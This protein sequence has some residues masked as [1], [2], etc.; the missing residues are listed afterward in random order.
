[1]EE[2]QKA[3]S[4][5]EVVETI[6]SWVVNKLESSIQSVEELINK[7][8]WDLHDCA[9]EVDRLEDVV[10]RAVRLQNDSGSSPSSP[11]PEVQLFKDDLRFFSSMVKSRIDYNKVYQDRDYSQ[12]EKRKQ[13]HLGYS[14]IRH[15]PTSGSKRD[16]LDQLTE[17]ISSK[18]SSQKKIEEAD[19][20]EI[21]IVQHNHQGSNKKRPGPNPYNFIEDKSA[22]G[23]QL[24]SSKSKSSTAHSKV[25]SMI[26]NLYIQDSFKV[27]PTDSFDLKFPRPQISRRPDH[28]LEHWHEHVDPHDQYI[29][30]NSS[31]VDPSPYKQNIE[32][33]INILDAERRQTHY[34]QRPR[35]IH[36]RDGYYSGIRR[37]QPESTDRSGETTMRE[38]RRETGG[39]NTERSY[40]RVQKSSYSP[41]Q[42]RR[43][44]AITDR[45][46]YQPLTINTQTYDDLVNQGV[47]ARNPNPGAAIPS[48]GTGSMENSL[49]VTERTE[50][51][52]I[53]NSTPKKKVKL[54]PGMSD[55]KP[56]EDLH[57]ISTKPINDGSKDQPTRPKS[58]L[59][60]K[61]DKSKSSS[62]QNIK[63]IIKYPTVIPS[64]AKML[65][66]LDVNNASHIPTM[67]KIEPS[68]QFT[69]RSSSKH[70]IGS[71]HLQLSPKSA[72]QKLDE[73]L[74][75]RTPSSSN[76]KKPSNISMKHDPLPEK[77]IPNTSPNKMTTS[78]SPES[79][80]DVSLMKAAN[81]FS[82]K[83][84][85]VSLTS[86][87]KSQQQQ[88]LAKKVIHLDEEDKSI[89]KKE[90]SEK[91]AQQTKTKKPS[92]PPKTV[93]E[94]VPILDKK[95][96]IKEVSEVK[97]NSFIHKKEPSKEIIYK[98]IP[99]K[100]IESV[101][102][103][104][105][106]SKQS[107]LPI[108]ERPK[109][110]TKIT[111]PSQIFNMQKPTSPS[112][113][114][115][116]STQSKP[117][118]E[119]ENKPSKP[120][121]SRP[122]SPRPN[123]EPKKSTES[124]KKPH[125]APSPPKPQPSVPPLAKPVDKSFTK[126]TTSP[127]HSNPASTSR[128]LTPVK[129]TP[130]PQ[131]PV[132]P[133]A[134]PSPKPTPSPAKSPPVAKQAAQQ[135]NSSVNK[136]PKAT[137]QP[138][139]F[140]NKV[141]ANQTP[142][143]SNT[144]KPAASLNTSKVIEGKNKTGEQTRAS[145]QKPI[146]TQPKQPD[147]P[148]AKS[149]QPAAKSTDKPAQPASKPPE[150]PQPQ[151][152]E[153]PTPKIVE[154]P[155]PVPRAS[156]PDLPSLAH[157]SYKSVPTPPLPLTLPPA[158]TQAHNPSSPHPFPTLPGLFTLPPPPPKPSSFG[159]KSSLTPPDGINIKLSPINADERMIVNIIDTGIA[160]HGDWSNIDGFSP[161]P[162][163]DE[164]SSE[165]IDNVA[166][167]DDDH[168]GDKQKGVD[169]PE[170]ENNDD[171]DEE[172]SEMPP[173]EVVH[174]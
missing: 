123:I 37:D 5:R 94:K 139:L 93:Q 80:K 164:D 56:K 14:E 125:P 109:T 36:S 147:K 70:S 149:P 135:L 119:V 112:P 102:K 59:Q 25:L 160:E 157:L 174:D 153:K 43:N 17:R 111:S 49:I 99:K 86:S 131:L 136:T 155:P 105:V 40:S 52:L 115:H 88:N 29:D 134:T 89:T 169:S 24:N 140:K 110:P 82:N 150:K 159:N 16:F 13:N 171:E 117:K 54:K 71:S 78:K 168:H 103:S 152:A 129:T 113:K 66:T 87:L 127:K 79:S 61:R 85:P 68:K 145:P 162:M 28:R 154:Q 97:E 64:E 21:F 20:E 55:E 32:R 31:S 143:R 132:K 57:N 38:E 172:S 108:N 77:V 67:N 83:V 23:T 146:Q 144:P 75:Q 10:S 73:R 9:V 156:I 72:A 53:R 46:H 44:K 39:S 96:P 1:M 63:N 90:R 2:G 30:L 4:N 60:E 138:D 42:A 41:L 137:Q 35:S 7:N 173:K 163:D 74:R 126:P 158:L 33:M 167:D 120:S 6:V 106:P 12:T 50:E 8:N 104:P 170:R 101:S 114:P 91:K 165:C 45:L 47:F 124:F 11:K 48:S 34:I 130:A 26:D 51:I 148:V 116:T 18:Q 121:T 69:G 142:P 98:P 19:G 118:L 92:S 22:T 141:A 133:K 15:M 95:E 107:Q 122:V 81:N 161:A 27:Q 151:P 100:P 76:K 166:I 62:S 128:N 58:K 3:L 65:P 84:H